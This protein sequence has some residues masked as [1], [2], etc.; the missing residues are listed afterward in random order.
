M[1]T[2]YIFLLTLT[3]SQAFASSVTRFGFSAATPNGDIYSQER[4]FAIEYVMSELSRVHKEVFDLPFSYEYI[5]G[6]LM[7]EIEAKRKLIAPNYP[8]REVTGDNQELAL[9]KFKEWYAAHP[10]E[11]TDYIQYVEQFVAD[12]K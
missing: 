6:T 4:P 2:V 9:E 12:H 7:V 8:S 3:F 1:K 5:K 10:Q 11:F